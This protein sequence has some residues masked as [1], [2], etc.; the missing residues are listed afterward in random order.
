MCINRNHIFIDLEFS[1]ASTRPKT[2]PPL[3]FSKEE[4]FLNQIKAKAEDIDPNELMM[5]TQ[6]LGSD[7]ELKHHYSNGMTYFDIYLTSQ[8]FFI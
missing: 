7:K 8:I 5:L 4:S 2:K 1:R 3:S 6:D